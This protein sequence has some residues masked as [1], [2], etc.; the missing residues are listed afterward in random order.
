V[1][2][3]WL[4]KSLRAALSSG[5]AFSPRQVSAVSAWLRLAA[6]TAVSGEYA[7]VVDV[8]N[9]NP[10]A[11]TDTDRKPAASTA[12]NGL[13][14]MVWDGT[15]VLTWPLQ[16]A[17]TGNNTR[18]AWGL[19]LWIKPTANVATRQR[20][21]NCTIATVGGNKVNVDI[22]SGGVETNFYLDGT[23]GRQMV[24]A[25]GITASVW[26]SLYVAFDGSKSATDALAMQLYVNKALLGTTY[27]N[28]AGGGAMTTLSNVTGTA[29]MGGSPD[30][31]TPSQPLL[32]GFEFGPNI[33]LFNGALTTAQLAALHNFERPT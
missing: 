12:A 14:T 24:I 7:I 1:S 6:S 19:F 30:S 22:V 11:Q 21:F 31:D 33:F 20:I 13:P 3:L 32:N 2:Q 26:Q 10:T 28:I 23:N 15:D 4:P 27:G 29:L 18:T 17:G 8:L 16:A 25:S 9:S 5:T